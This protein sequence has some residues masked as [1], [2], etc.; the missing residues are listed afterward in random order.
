MSG[1]ATLIEDLGD[2]QLY[3]VNETRAL[4]LVSKYGSGFYGN[5]MTCVWS[6]N[7]DAET[8]GTPL[9]TYSGCVT[10]DEALRRFGLE[11]KA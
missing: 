2:D 4:L 11:V 5:Q 3:R 8:N 1:T 7:R 6:A 10:H 9:A